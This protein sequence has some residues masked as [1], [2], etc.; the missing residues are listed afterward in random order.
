MPLRRQILR[1]PPIARRDAEIRRLKRRVEKLQLAL[2]DEKAKPPPPPPPPA[3]PRYRP[4]V[5]SWHVRVMEQQ[6]VQ[7]AVG[8][9]PGSTDHPRRNLLLKLQNYEIARSYGVSTPQVLGVWPTVAE[10]DF[11]ALPDEFVLKSNG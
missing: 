5:A 1:L 8:A 7:Q 3:P 10:I 11:D 9:L 6:R 2:A 4:K